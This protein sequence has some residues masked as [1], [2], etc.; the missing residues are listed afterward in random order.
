MEIAEKEENPIPTKKTHRGGRTKGTTLEQ[1]Y[2]RRDRVGELR[3]QGLHYSEIQ[4]KLLK[5][6]SLKGTPPIKVSIQQIK[7]DYYNLLEARRELLSTT[8]RIEHLQL[9]FDK[10]LQAGWTSYFK[11]E[12]SAERNGAIREIRETLLKISKLYGINLEG[13][14]KIGDIIFGS[15]QEINIFQS[16]REVLMEVD[17]NARVEFLRA[18]NKRKLELAVEKG[19]VIEGT[20]LTKEFG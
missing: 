19:A 13:E 1:I 14:V 18:L 12:T 10:L 7:R 9:S 6:D 11:A 8:R 4:R 3:A 16:F 17:E 15:K 2:K 20:P 5:G